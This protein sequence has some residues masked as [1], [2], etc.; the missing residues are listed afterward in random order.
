MESESKRGL[1]VV[2]FFQRT[3]IHNYTYVTVF[4]TTGTNTM[5]T[6]YVPTFFKEGH[7]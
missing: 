2:S 7:I 5:A 1:L 3:D 6:S 4:K